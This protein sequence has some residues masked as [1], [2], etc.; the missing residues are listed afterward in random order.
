[1]QREASVLL[2]ATNVVDDSLAGL[3]YMPG[4]LP[5]YVA[6][7]RPILLIGP[8]SSEAARAVRHWGWA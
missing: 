5:E 2:V 3:G 4:R 1:M 7:G 8:E 6:A